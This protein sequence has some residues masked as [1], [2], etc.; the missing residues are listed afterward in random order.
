[1]QKFNKHRLF[2]E[3][4]N[5]SKIDRTFIRIVNGKN[6]ENFGLPGLRDFELYIS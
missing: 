1:M 5:F 3:N 2:G 4:R 6:H